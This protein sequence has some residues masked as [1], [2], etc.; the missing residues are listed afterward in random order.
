MKYIE[1]SDRSQLILFPERLDDLVSEE[2]PV[3]FID[4]YVDTLDL[5]K[6]GFTKT[7]INTALPGRPCYSPASLVKLYVYGYFK[8]VRSSRKL[9]E[10]CYINIEMMWLIGRIMPDFRTI[11]DFRKDNAI[12]LKTVFKEFV[13]M[14]VDLGLYRTEVGVQDG[15]KFRAVNSKDQNVTVPKLQKK[16]EV[17]EE[18]INKYLEEME[19][20]DREES[21]SP[22]FTKEEIQKKIE[23]LLKRKEQYGNTVNEMKEKGLTQISFIDP[24]SK[25]M[26]TANGG[27][28][29]CFNTQ[30]VVDPDSHMIG[31][32]KVTDNCNDLGL[33]SPIMT[34]A[35]EDLGVDV[36]EVVADKGYEDK[37]D[38]LECIMN[39]IIPN[40]PSVSGKKD[41]EFEV[42]YKET[43]ITE[44]QQDSA[45]PEAIRGCLEAGVIPNVYKDKGI[46]VTVEEEEQ[47][48]SD[49]RSDKVFTLNEEGTAVMCPNGSSLNK[50]ATMYNSGRVRFA[51][52]SACKEC[53]E[54]CTASKFKQ[55]DL[56]KGQT[57]YY[58]KSIQK[59]KKVVIR[60]TPDTEKIKIRKTIVE[61]PFG[62]VKRWQDGSY[63]LLKGKVKAEADLALSFLAYNIKRAISMVGVRGLIE[64]MRVIIEAN[65]AVI[66]YLFQI[67]I[68]IR[69]KPLCSF[70]FS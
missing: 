8:K 26:K 13:K 68:K 17:V 32:F 66:F 48:V 38:M 59:V 9:M 22:K 60:L 50:V 18:K 63:L 39:G 57:V 41:Y 15:S 28:D 12:A 35:K 21:D 46:E 7:S 65:I 34:A 43:V 55:V 4:A 31:A 49:E 47:C 53:D 6:I 64:R 29:V 20:N 58:A 3:R 23:E 69:Q 54:K 24:E 5:A 25:L 56:K 67:P 30:I 51:C 52:R 33:L 10:Q 37:A 40:V 2:N 1:S 44:E 61:H 16:Q 36:M 27:F 14:C 11:A 62:T 70:V 42:D 19:K 45:D